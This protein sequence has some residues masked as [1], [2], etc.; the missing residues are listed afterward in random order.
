MK[1]RVNLIIK[2]R[3]SKL[4]ITGVAAATV[5]IGATLM[6]SFGKG[7]SVPV[8]SYTAIRVFDGDTF[9]TKEKQY[10]RLSGINTPEMG[11]CGSEEAKKELEKLILDKA[12]YVKVL[13]HIGSRS[14]GLVY[15]DEGLVSTAMLASGWAE[16][17]DRE[18]LDLQEL[19]DATNQARKKKVGIFS[20]LCTQETN[21]KNPSCS[22][23]ANVTTNGIPTYHFPGCQTYATT[24]L[25]LHHGDRWFCTEKEAVK[26][27]FRKA[28]TC[29]NTGF[30]PTRE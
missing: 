20:N 13:Y 12:L 11:Q 27:G 7:K 5:A 24:K 2:P 10:I 4:K 3:F 19:K 14:M 16:M 29:P 1:E 23:K 30:P 6:L 8:P 15:T 9:E 21:P 18:N 26:A 28:K 25:E 22:I 17:N